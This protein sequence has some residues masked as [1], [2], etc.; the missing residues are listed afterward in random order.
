MV[1]RSPIQLILEWNDKY[2]VGTPVYVTYPSGGKRKMKT[3]AEAR[4][5]NGRKA[6][7]WVHG[8]R[9]PVEL[10]MVEPVKKR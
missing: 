2:P 10:E 7:I 5:L 4:L 9:D 8:T 3:R 6:V 1:K